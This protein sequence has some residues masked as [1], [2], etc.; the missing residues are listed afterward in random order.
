MKLY[1]F[2]HHSTEDYWPIFDHFSCPIMLQ[3]RPVLATLDLALVFA[4][5]VNSLFFEIQ[6]LTFLD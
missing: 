1:H 4:F 6:I 3:V 5:S 2:I